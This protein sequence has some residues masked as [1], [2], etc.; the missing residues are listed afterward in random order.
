MS[1]SSLMLDFNQLFTRKITTITSHLA[2]LSQI[3][4]VICIRVETQRAYKIMMK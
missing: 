4:I 3:K 2:K 1:F